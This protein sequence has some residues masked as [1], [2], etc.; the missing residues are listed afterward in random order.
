MST[1]Q[2]DTGH[3]AWSA[4]AVGHA[5]DSLEPE[6]EQSFLSHLPGCGVCAGVVADTR[7]VMGHLAYAVD[8]VDPPP[9]LRTA[10]RVG[11]AGTERPPVEV[12]ARHTGRPRRRPVARLGGRPWMAVAAGLAL[13]MALSVWNVVLQAQN[14]SQDRRLHQSA[15]ITDCLREVGCRTVELRT[16]TSDQPRATA[17]VRAREVQLVVTGL[18]RNDTSAEVY[19]LWQRVDQTKFTA[20]DTFDITRPGVTVIR[21][22]HLAGDLNRLG[23]LAV[24]REPG[25]RMPP[26]PSQVVAL[27]TVPA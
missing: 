3:D 15:L 16:P 18:P 25:R 19:V 24:S 11:I 9:A 6:D 26:A 21:T 20:L 27:G 10:I 14:R 13:L 2:P 7:I 12:Q 8:P 17:L 23:A 4:L 5:L 1:Q 22:R